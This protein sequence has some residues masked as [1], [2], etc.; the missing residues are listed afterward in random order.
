MKE[1]CSVFSELRQSVEEL[2]K[3]PEYPQPYFDKSIKLIRAL[4]SHN[5]RNPDGRVLVDEKLAELKGYLEQLAGLKRS[6]GHTL[7]QYSL[8]AYAALD[9]IEG[10]HGLSIE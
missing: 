2:A 7:E 1:V 5:A 6:G 10:P 4:G 8:W 3:L 9:A